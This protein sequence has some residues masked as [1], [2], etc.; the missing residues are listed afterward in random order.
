MG[1]PHYIKALDLFLTKKKNIQVLL[2]CFK[3]L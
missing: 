3:K 1:G 2:A